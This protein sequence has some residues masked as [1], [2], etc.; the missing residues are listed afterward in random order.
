MSITSAAT[1]I[2]QDHGIVFVK[3]DDDEVHA[4]E[5]GE[6]HETGSPKH[7]HHDKL[8]QDHNKHAQTHAHGKEHHKDEHHDHADHK[9]KSFGVHFWSPISLRPGTLLATPT[10]FTKVTTS[11]NV[12][13]LHHNLKHEW[14]QTKGEK[15]FH[16][17]ATFCTHIMKDQLKA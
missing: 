13:A 7:N 2:E 8:H 1:F 5:F 4:F 12:E 11:M 6:H 17:A 16:D 10:N 14:H 15:V 9:A 3:T